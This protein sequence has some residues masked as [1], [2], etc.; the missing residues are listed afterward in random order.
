MFIIIV[1]IITRYPVRGECVLQKIRSTPYRKL[2]VENES[3]GEK[4][5]QINFQWKNP[6]SFHFLYF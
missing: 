3:Y 2:P 5:N 6:G 4:I 1:Q